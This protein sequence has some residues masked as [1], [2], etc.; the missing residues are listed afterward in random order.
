ML[1]PRE[2]DGGDRCRQGARHLLGMQAQDR[3]RRGPPVA[4]KGKAHP[5][6]RRQVARV[7]PGPRSTC[8]YLGTLRRTCK[9]HQDCHWRVRPVSRNRL[10]SS[11]EIWT[12]RRHIS[13]PTTRQWS[14]P[15]LRPYR[16]SADDGHGPT[17]SAR[18]RRGCDS[19]RKSLPLRP[20]WS[21]APLRPVVRSQPK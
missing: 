14:G 4:H 3:P 20:S 1:P 17:R 8:F 2:A 16:S 18:D 11:S 13:P 21:V 10:A 19:A 12:M 6:G 15:R 7:L 5:L 9:N